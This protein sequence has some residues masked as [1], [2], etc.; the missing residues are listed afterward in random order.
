MLSALGST[1]YSAFLPGSPWRTTRRP[2]VWSHAW[3]TRRNRRVP[4]P[5]PAAAPSAAADPLAPPA[6]ARRFRRDGGPRRAVRASAV[7]HP[8]EGLQ[9]LRQRVP[10]LRPVGERRPLL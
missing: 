5:R 2:R 3:T 6:R 9:D 7:R 4:V 10:H 8:P 1:T